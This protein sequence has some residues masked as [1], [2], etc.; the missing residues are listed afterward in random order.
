MTRKK[1]TLNEAISK[2]KCNERYLKKQRR[3]LAV[4]MQHYDI[5]SFERNLYDNYDENY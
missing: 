5:Y 3:P 2:L 1:I 4:G